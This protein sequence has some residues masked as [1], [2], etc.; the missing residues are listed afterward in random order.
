MR[1]DM[2]IAVEAQR[3]AAEILPGLGGVA[4]IDADMR[5]LGNAPCRAAAAALPIAKRVVIED[6]DAALGADI[7]VPVLAR[8]AEQAGR[9]VGEGRIQQIANGLGDLDWHSCSP[10]ARRR[11]GLLCE[12]RE[13]ARFTSTRQDRAAVLI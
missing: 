11:R 10:L 4:I 5:V 13:I 3:A 9:A 8:R 2:D 12:C 1:Q 7:R 6:D